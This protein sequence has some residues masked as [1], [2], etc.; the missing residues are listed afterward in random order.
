[1]T[2]SNVS[3]ATDTPLDSLV[4]DRIVGKGQRCFYATR[5]GRVVGMLTV[6]DVSEVPRASWPTSIVEDAM[7]PRDLVNFVTPSTSLVVAIRALD[8][9][10]CDY[11]PVVED[12]MLV[13]TLSR[14]QV[15]TY[16]QTRSKLGA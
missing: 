15:V 6:A 11:L 8:E 3:V 5:D 16:L 4:N 14:D 9:F 1:M 7:V 13:G 12:G 10:T 2:R